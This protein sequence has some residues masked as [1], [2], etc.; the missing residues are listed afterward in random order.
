M[1][2]LGLDTATAD[3]CV[4]LLSDTDGVPVRLSRHHRPAAGERPGHAEQLLR[5]T[6]ELLHEASLTWTAVDRIAVG[7]G[8]GTFTGLRIGVASARALAQASGTQL[9]AVS[10]LHALAQAAASPAHAD[11]PPPVLV[12]IDARRGEVFAGAW[13]GGRCVLPAQ[14]TPPE[15]L[16]ALVAQLTADAGDELL[17]VGDGA[18]RYR[19]AFDATAA[20][21]PADD[22]LRHRVDGLAICALARHAPAADRDTL[23]PDYVRAPD[24]KR[25]P[26]A[27]ATP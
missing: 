12:C 8:P 3:T 13:A 6:A 27:G 20:T 9:A 22:D 2:V 17:T 23:M 10:T 14:A 19:D 1:I 18:V 16:P 21:I 7:V 26:R 11:Q 25:R 5:L 4:G 15:A 24:A